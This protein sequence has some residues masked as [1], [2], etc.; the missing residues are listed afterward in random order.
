MVY[1][2]LKRAFGR[3]GF[4]GPSSCGTNLTSTETATRTQLDPTPAEPHILKSTSLTVAFELRKMNDPHS[5]SSSTAPLSNQAQSYSN[6]RS[7]FSTAAAFTPY[8]TSFAQQARV[9]AEQPRKTAS[10]NLRRMMLLNGY[11]LGYLILWTPGVINRFIE[12]KGMS[13][14]PWLVAL[15]AS[16]Q[17]IGLV[18]AITYGYN[19]QLRRSVRSWKAFRQRAERIED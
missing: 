8:Q 3:F 14:P 16:T 1:F 10:P 9:P 7:H 2:Q 15:L 19:E 12:I 13:S 18:H 5:D 11:P 4:S 17:Y 6:P